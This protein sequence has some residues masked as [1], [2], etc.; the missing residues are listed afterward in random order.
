MNRRECIRLI[1]FACIGCSSVVLAITP[2]EKQKL[3]NEAK[4][5]YESIITPSKVFGK[6]AHVKKL[7]ML[8]ALL[9][10][11]GITRIQTLLEGYLGKDNDEYK[12]MLPLAK[13]LA[14][15]L[16][17]FLPEKSLP[18]SQH[19]IA[20]Y[21]WAV[22]DLAADPSI[23]TYY[24]RMKVTDKTMSLY[25]AERK[26]KIPATQLKNLL[27]DELDVLNERYMPIL[28]TIKAMGKKTILPPITELKT[29]YKDILI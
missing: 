6:D 29:L 26:S 18:I 4:K 13:N 1:S 3:I 9:I 5:S 16:N 10:Q 25:E 24:E 17:E 22:G 15:S 14:K 21:R 12:K 19:I 7:E 11:K 2:S 8:G 27:D 20:A 23:A 28:E